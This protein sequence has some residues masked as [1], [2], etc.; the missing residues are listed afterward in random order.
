[1][2]LT[3]CRLPDGEINSEQP[4]FG[5]A[6]ESTRAARCGRLRSVRFANANQLAARVA[7][8]FSITVCKTCCERIDERART[9]VRNCVDQAIK[10][11]WGMSWRS[12]AMKGVEGCDN[13]GGAVK[14][15]LIP[16]SLN[17]CQLNT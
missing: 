3:I 9:R 15:A 2:L 13:L 14:Q 1:M 11:I 12:K 6:C 17:Y 8:V 4:V 7:G 5:L 10:G 16:R